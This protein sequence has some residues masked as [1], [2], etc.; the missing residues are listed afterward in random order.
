MPP[1]TGP[2]GKAYVHADGSGYGRNEL[3]ITDQAKDPGKS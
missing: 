1:I 2:D 3:M